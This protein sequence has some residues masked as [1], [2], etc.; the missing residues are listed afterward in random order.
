M[1]HL[2]TICLVFAAGT[3]LVPGAGA[4]GPQSGPMPAAAQKN[5]KAWKPGGR[6]TRTSPRWSRRCAASA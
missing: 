3:V 2:K 1:K 5:M 4:Q 6:S